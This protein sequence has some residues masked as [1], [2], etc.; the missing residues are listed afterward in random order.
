MKQ[1]YF[2]LD[3]KPEPDVQL[4]SRCKECQAP[5]LILDDKLCN[6]HA[7][8][9]FVPSPIPLQ[10]PAIPS[11]TIQRFQ[12]VKD[13]RL[14]RL[15]PMNSS[16]WSV[17]QLPHHQLVMR[18]AGGFNNMSTI[19]KPEVK[20][21]FSS[22]SGPLIVKSRRPRD[23]TQRILQGERRTNEAMLTEQSRL[24]LDGSNNIQ[25]WK[26]DDD[27]PINELQQ[28][29]E[30]RAVMDSTPSA[31]LQAQPKTKR[32]LL[33]VNGSNGNGVVIRGPIAIIQNAGVGSFNRYVN[34][35]NHHPY[36]FFQ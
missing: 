25:V 28:Q 29:C 6:L 21:D 20:Y 19:R 8:K 11:Q 3:L 4:L 17:R 34:S 12:S 13:P 10:S 5:C 2:R 36:F 33:R 35:L 15:A 16:A 7:K 26:I 1:A 23:T 9:L 32:S 22:L 14:S 18:E 30:Q 31:P 24:K 27:L